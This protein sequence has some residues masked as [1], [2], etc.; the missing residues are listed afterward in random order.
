[1]PG[2][3]VIPQGGRLGSYI[4]Q[5]IQV[6]AY[7]DNEDWKNRIKLSTELALPVISHHAV[8]APIQPPF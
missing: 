3:I 6:F 4:E 1:M 8:A 2:L 7:D 5:I